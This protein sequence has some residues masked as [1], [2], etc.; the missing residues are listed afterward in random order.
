[1]D[2]KGKKILVVGA[3]KSGISVARFLMQKEA[4]VTLTDNRDRDKFN[5]ELDDLLAS[6]VR[7]ELGSYP[8][9]AP[10]VFDLVVVSPGVPPTVAP[11][12]SARE[13]GVP[14][15][16]E[17]ELAWRFARTP[18]IAITGTNGKTTTTALV[19]EIFRAAG[20]KALV[21]G[22]IG[23]PL[24]D[25]VEDYGPGD[26]IVAEV[27]SFQLE[28]VEFFRPRVALITNITPDH[29]DRHGTME[30]YTAAKAKIFTRQGD[31]DYTV[32]NYDDPKTRA[33]AGITPGKVIFFSRRHILEEGVFVHKGNMLLRLG[34]SATEIMPIKDIAIPGGHNL[35]NALAAAAAAAVLGVS[36]A[37]LE[38]TLRTFPGVAHRLE[39]VAEINGVKYVNDS[40]GTNPEASIKALE[41]F[42][43]PIVLLAG[44]RNKGSDFTEFARLARQKTRVMVILGECAAEIEQAARQAGVTNILKAASFNEAVLMA[45][46]AAKSGDVVLL[47][48]ACASWD[49]FKNYEERGELFRQIVYDL[50]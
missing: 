38:Q 40:K 11:V 47:S 29:L 27:S 43:R 28:T 37:L 3:G 26:I 8:E 32:L 6:G 49:M 45:H 50:K 36:P 22:N 20:Y 39:T 48:P 9:V 25:V 46:G 24:V 7:A 17:L 15:T 41:A 16:G 23:V 18:F 31:G 12:V 42:D 2:V 21:G 44:G 34:G 1:M 19:G 30:A 5:G 35:E 10:G 13:R 4:I 33:L 14:V